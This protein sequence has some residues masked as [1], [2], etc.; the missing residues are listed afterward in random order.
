MVLLNES[1]E[2]PD[3]KYL[4][5][6]FTFARCHGNLD[7]TGLSDQ[8]AAFFPDSAGYNTFHSPGKAFR[9]NLEAG[10]GALFEKEPAKCP[11]V[12]WTQSVY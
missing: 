7:V 12:F 11:Q 10:C 9:K 8:L 1:A 3:D 5:Q 2:L 6:Q 4:L